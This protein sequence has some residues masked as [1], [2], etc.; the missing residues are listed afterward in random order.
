MLKYNHSSS[1]GQL[2]LE[3]IQLLLDGLF[4]VDLVGLL[5]VCLCVIVL[6]CLDVGIGSSD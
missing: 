3:I 1:L 4:R 6:V 5:Q 2:G